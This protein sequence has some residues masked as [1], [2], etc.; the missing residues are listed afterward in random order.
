MDPMH[1]EFTQVRYAGTLQ[2]SVADDDACYFP[3]MGEIQQAQSRTIYWRGREYAVLIFS[4][5]D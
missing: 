3:E 1:V 2:E 5:G 4:Y